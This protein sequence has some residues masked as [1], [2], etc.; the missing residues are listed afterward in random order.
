MTKAEAAR[1][2]GLAVAAKYGPEHMA[3]IGR[4]GGERLVERRGRRHMKEIG[5]RGFEATLERHWDG[6]R[7]A[8]IDDLTKRGLMAVDPNPENGAWQFDLSSSP[9]GAP[10]SE[11]PA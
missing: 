1:L 7:A 4:R 8:M 10:E 5:R 11:A 6:D 9:Y 3:A 2:G